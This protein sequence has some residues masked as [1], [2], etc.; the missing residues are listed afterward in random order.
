MQ[1]RELTGRTLNEDVSVKGK[2]VAKLGTVVNEK[3]AA[4]ISKS[5]AEKIK[6][7]PYITNNVAYFDAEYERT[8]I[9][10]A[11]SEV[12]EM[13]ELV[14]TRVASRTYRW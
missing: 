12:N 14:Q 9:A 2:I 5:E 6:V 3:L 7:R 10:Q 1:L 4:E 11:N 8:C 13:G